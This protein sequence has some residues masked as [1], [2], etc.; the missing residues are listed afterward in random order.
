MFL[1]NP[2]NFKLRSDFSY[3]KVKI[4]EK[5]LNLIKEIKTTIFLLDPQNAPWF[6]S[7][8]YWP[9]PGT[10]IL[11]EPC[12]S[13]G[14]YNKTPK[15]IRNSSDH[16][17]TKDPNA[18]LECVKGII[19]LGLRKYIEKIISKPEYKYILKLQGALPLIRFWPGAFIETRKDF[20]KVFDSDI[21]C[22]LQIEQKCKSWKIQISDKNNDWD[23]IEL[24]DGEMLIYDQHNCLFGRI[25][26]LGKSFAENYFIDGKKSEANQ[27]YSDQMFF[28]FKYSQIK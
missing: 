9:P 14:M 17:D 23:E 20:T 13:D 10:Q 21:C 8:G 5:V 26:P 7:K 19:A 1:E 27:P 18:P 28:Y 16:F 11:A 15:G 2:Q 6:G 24:Q 12:D 3:K 22:V 4:P 25:D